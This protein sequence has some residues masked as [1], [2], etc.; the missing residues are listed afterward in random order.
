[1]GVGWADIE[2]MPPYE[3]AAHL[4]HLAL[5]LNTELLIEPPAPA[6]GAT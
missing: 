3:L 5:V 1:M 4:E 2:D 6:E